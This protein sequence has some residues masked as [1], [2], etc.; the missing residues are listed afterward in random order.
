MNV[1]GVLEIAAELFRLFL[2]ERIPRDNWAGQVSMWSDLTRD[3]LNSPS[4]AC[5]T[6]MASLAEVSKYGIPPLDWQKVMARF[7][8]IFHLSAPILKPPFTSQH[9]TLLLSS[10]SILLPNTTNGKLSGS[11]GEAWIKNSSLQLS[12]ASKLLELLT[13]YTSTQQSAPL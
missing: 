4:K 13:S 11:R 8:E 1:D 7:V 9:T 12:S 3:R 10:T 2:E 6:L 5:S